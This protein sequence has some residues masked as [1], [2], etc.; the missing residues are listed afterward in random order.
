MRAQLP[1]ATTTCRQPHHRADLG[2]PA[3]TAAALNYQ[4]ASIGSG[5][6]NPWAAP[7]SRLTECRC[8]TGRSSWS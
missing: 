3:S 2:L 7:V 6:T 1:E 8:S 4:G 5:Q